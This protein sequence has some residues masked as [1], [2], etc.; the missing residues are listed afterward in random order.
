MINEGK[1]GYKSLSGGEKRRVDIIVILS[2]QRFLLECTGVSTN[3]LVFDEIFD[4]LDN[5]GI[6][7]V[8][9][10][11][12]TIFDEGLCVYIITHKSDFRVSFESFVEIEK[13]NDI[14]SIVQ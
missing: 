8:L 12:D 7:M 3:L 10:C 11:I 4:S 2:L 14:S 6:Q 1:R 13:V 5:V 9:N